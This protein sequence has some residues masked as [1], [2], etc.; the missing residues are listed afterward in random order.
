MSTQLT[1]NSLMQSPAI[2]DRITEVLGEKRA[3][4]FMAAVIQLSQSTGLAKCEPKSILG[5][6]MQAATLELAINP[7][8][9]HAYVVPYGQSAQFQIGYKGLIQLAQRSGKVTSIND[10]VV[11]GGQLVSFDPMT[12]HLVVD[13][14]REPV[15]EPDGYGVFLALTNGFKKVVFWPRAKV[16]KHAERFSQAFK[17]GWDCPWKSDFDSMA[18]KTVMKQTLSKYAPLSVE[19][20]QAI[21]SDQGAIDIETGE[22]KYID[23]PPQIEEQIANVPSMDEDEGG[24][25]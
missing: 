14:D 23:H 2:R 19:V 25:E 5:A 17:K 10:F 7:T 20:Q 16:L 15:G 4:A 6:A 22:V 24:D 13:W 21:A 11:G 8:L 3:P 1:I 9:G 18:L 12:G